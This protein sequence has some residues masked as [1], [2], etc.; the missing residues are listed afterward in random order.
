MVYLEFILVYSVRVRYESIPCLREEKLNPNQ[1][2]T[3]R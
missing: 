2:H 3:L 1:A